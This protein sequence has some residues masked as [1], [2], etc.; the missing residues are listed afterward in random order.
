MY[1]QQIAH[2]PNNM[3]ADD[4]FSHIETIIKPKR[5]AG[6]LHD[7][8]L[9]DD[10]KTPAD[11]HIHIM[12]QFDNARSV[13]QVAKDI[14]DAP[15]YLEIWNDNVN[16]GFAYLIHATKNARYKHQYSCDEV[17][18]N[19][20]YAELI[21]LLVKKASKVEGMTA[22]NQ[23]NGLL[24]MV[25]S[26]QM[27]LKEAKKQL[28]GSAYAK[29]SAKLER[30]HELYLE[31]RADELH[32][33]ME[34]NNELVS[35][36]WFFGETETGKTFLAQKLAKE[37]GDYYLT[38]TTQDAFQYYQ[39]EP[40][41]ILDELRPGTIPYSE[42][43]AVCNPFSHGRSTVSSRY[44]NKPLAC[45]TFFITSPY[46]PW[47]YCKYCNLDSYDKGDQLFRR[48]SSV[49]MFDANYIY[50]MT[51]D[52]SKGVY[53]VT[54]QKDNPYSKKKQTTYQ[55]KNVFDEI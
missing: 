41:I 53:S 54:A 31:R 7:H 26:G 52:E 28:S 36:H 55:L 35:V 27:T 46:S 8:D 2:L 48:L 34:D 25:G 23:I 50:K 38:S 9:K 19:F 21:N 4:L 22:S 11:D 17:R 47:Q 15:Q 13:N 1:T 16:N 33:S 3:T 12:M 29:A 40:V 10:N 32:R 30:A 24:D 44:Y 5:W 51:Y 45:R 14:G 49:L 43:L 6:I 18:A 42:L 39:A 20:D 37:L